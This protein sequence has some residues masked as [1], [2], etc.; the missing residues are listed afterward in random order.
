[1]S[2]EDQIVERI[3]AVLPACSLQLHRLFGLLRIRFSDD[4]TTACVTC[5]ARPELVLN[6]S[7]VDLFCRSDEHLFMLVM[8][9]LYHVI[10]GHTSLFPKSTPTLNIVFDAVINAMLCREYPQREYTSF[11]TQL[12]QP[13]RLPH[14]LL[15]PP[16]P[17]TELP[18]PAAAALAML[19][20]SESCGTYYDVFQA[21]RECVLPAGG[22]LLL[23]SH[24]GENESENNPEIRALVEAIAKRWPRPP[25]FLDRRALGGAWKHDAYGRSQ[26]GAAFIRGVRQLLQ[27]AGL[28]L[29]WPGGN[30]SG[31]MRQPVPVQSFLP[32]PR[33]RTLAARRELQGEVLLSTGELTAPRRQRAMRRRALVYLDV[34]GSMRD[35][36]PYLAG[37]MA[38]FVR[39]RLC[40]L[41]IFSTEVR[42]VSLSELRD[43]RFASTGGTSINCV[44]EHYLTLPSQ[45]RPSRL[46]VLTDGYTGRPAASLL[47]RCRAKLY[48]GLVSSSYRDDLEDAAADIVALPALIKEEQ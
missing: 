46:V 4:V 13:G 18:Q 25:Q 3:Y 45:A 29:G 23:G 38:P 11:F 37:A 21:L 19:Y 32:S 26:P 48:C 15:R 27:R 31:V 12:Y 2:D 6:K 10:L 14:A 39:A 47:Q 8:H 44:L 5:R 16:E 7:F 40:T 9:E 22:V 41:F 30:R 35:F 36:L 28:R 20:G 33:D 34:S 42:P 1:M 24:G 17:G 43:G